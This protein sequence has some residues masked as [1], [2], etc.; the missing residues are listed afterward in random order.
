MRHLCADPG[1]RVQVDEQG[2]VGRGPAGFPGQL[3]AGGGQRLFGGVVTEAGGQFPEVLT[4]GMPVLAD[5]EDTSR[6][7]DGDHRHRP[8]VL[9][10]LTLGLRAVGLGDSVRP[11]PD[12]GAV[13]L[14]LAGA[15]FVCHLWP[16][17]RREQ[18]K[19]PM[20]PLTSAEA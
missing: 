14:Q 16:L 3:A 12:D 18:A 4:R 11:D 1:G 7:V 9:D 5:Q 2:P 19:L 10:H 17:P 13:V 6:V 15:N 20:R 8:G